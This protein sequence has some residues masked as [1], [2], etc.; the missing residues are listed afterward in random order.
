MIHRQRGN[1]RFRAYTKAM[2]KYRLVRQM[3]G[4]YWYVEHLGM[5]RKGK[6]HCS[7]PMC[8]EK[9]NTRLSKSRGSVYAEMR[10]GWTHPIARGTRIP[11]TCS[12]YGK[13]NYTAA[14]K[15]SIDR[16]RFQ[17]KEWEEAS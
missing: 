3:Q 8:A 5:L 2:R 7:C 17:I 14:E 10:K 11:T 4:E 12:R 9:T 1:R 15:R 13:K 6:I 16:M